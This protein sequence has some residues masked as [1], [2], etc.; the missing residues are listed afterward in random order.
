MESIIE[1]ISTALILAELTPD[2]LLR[3]TNKAN[4]ELYVITH[5]KRP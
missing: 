3:K 2:K 4:N 1:P 5:H